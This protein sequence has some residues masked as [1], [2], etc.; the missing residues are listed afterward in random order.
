MSP[1]TASNAKL[2]SCSFAFVIKQLGLGQFKASF[3]VIEEKAI[4]FI[5][6]Q[7]ATIEVENQEE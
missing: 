6:I 2:G 3:T 5:I 1:I 7:S 4:A